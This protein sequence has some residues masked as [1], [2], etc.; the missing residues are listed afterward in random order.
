MSLNN[1]YVT[2]IKNEVKMTLEEG[3]QDK[4]WFIRI[5]ILDFTNQEVSIFNQQTFGL[6]SW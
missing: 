5:W 6:H 3:R 2:V 1:T 4:T